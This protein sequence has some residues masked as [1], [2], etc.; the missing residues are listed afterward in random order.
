MLRGAESPMTGS[1]IAR[2]ALVVLAVV[3]LWTGISFVSQQ[4][5]TVWTDVAVDGD[6]VA[7]EG[8]AVDVYGIGLVLLAIGLLVTTT[9]LVFEAYIHPRRVGDVA[10]EQTRDDETV[11]EGQP[12]L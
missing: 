12:D 8:R 1:G 5:V 2:F 6:V 10:D 9:I 4:E 3:L 11:S 7:S